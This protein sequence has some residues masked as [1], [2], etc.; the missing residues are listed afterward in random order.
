MNWMTAFQF[1]K[2]CNGGNPFADLLV[3]EKIDE[4]IDFML[5]EGI[6]QFTEGN[7]IMIL[8]LHG[9]RSASPAYGNLMNLNAMI[10]Q[11]FPIA[12]ADAGSGQNNIKGYLLLTL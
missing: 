10:V 5:D 7:E 9:K 12:E 3:N 1:L 11:Y 8:G 4:N 6:I 2:K